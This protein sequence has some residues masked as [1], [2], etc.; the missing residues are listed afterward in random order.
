MLKDKLDD[1][2]E[3]KISSFSFRKYFDE[4]M[5]SLDFEG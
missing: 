5:I 3:R 4:L 1:G 2:Y